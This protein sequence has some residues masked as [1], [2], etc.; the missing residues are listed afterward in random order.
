[1]HIYSSDLKYVTVAMPSLSEQAAIASFLDKGTRDAES[2]I[3]RARRRIELLREY[4]T[5]V[6]ADVV[7][8]KLDVRKAVVRLGEVDA[9]DVEAQPGGVDVRP[10]GAGWRSGA[11]AAGPQVDAGDAG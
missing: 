1:M 7:T 3:N 5:R 10:E 11:E 4:G 6:I 9:L 2:G 8:G